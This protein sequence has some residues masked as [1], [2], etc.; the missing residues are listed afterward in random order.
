MKTP[1]KKVLISFIIADLALLTVYELSKCLL[2]IKHL[3]YR[4]TVNYSVYAALL[5]ITLGISVQVIIFLFHRVRRQE[6]PAIR[7]LAVVG[8]AVIIVMVTIA[9][10]NVFIRSVF[11][12]RPEHVIEKNGQIMLARVDSFLQVEVRY[13]DHVNLLVRGSWTRIHEDYGNGGYDPFTL[14]EMPE[15]RRYM[16]FDKNGEVIDSNW[17]DSYWPP[18]SSDGNASYDVQSRG[19]VFEE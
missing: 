9:S 19:V 3:A 1:H 17:T 11:G 5:V 7:I 13:Y 6:K 10:L 16:Y 12:H 4:N 2:R 18:S 8:I 15:V 14:D